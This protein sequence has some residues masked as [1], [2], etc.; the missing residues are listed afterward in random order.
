MPERILRDWTDSEKFDGFQGNPETLFTRLIM[1][2]DDYGRFTRDPINVRAACFPRAEALR[3]NTVDAWLKELSDHR[4][5]LCYQVS[6]KAYLA[7]INFRQRLR[8]DPKTQRGPNPKYPP[9]DGKPVDFRPDDGDWRESAASSGGSPPYAYAESNANAVPLAVNPPPIPKSGLEKGS[10]EKPMV[11]E[12]GSCREV[13]DEEQAVAMTMTSGIDEKFARF[14][15]RQWAMQNGK[16]GNGIVVGWVAYVTGRWKNEQVE[17]KNGT[18]RGNRKTSGRVN[19]RLAGQS[20]DAQVKRSSIAAA[21][22][23]SEE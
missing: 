13:P 20:D 8:I 7:I 15:Y 22:A 21:L 11:G 23:A 10:G 17:W 9:P 2:V 6:G 12:S 4:L 19:P 1:K 16:N 14:A 18:H 5:I 3:A